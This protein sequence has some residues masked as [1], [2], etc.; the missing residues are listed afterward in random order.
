MTTMAF[1]DI[2]HFLFD[3]SPLQVGLAIVLVILT[4]IFLHNFVFNASSL[5]Q[6]PSILLI[7]PS[8][9]GKT[10]LLTLVRPDFGTTIESMLT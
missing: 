2:V 7:G 4:P 5:T 6:L 3:L 8:G 10:S 9:A 1:S